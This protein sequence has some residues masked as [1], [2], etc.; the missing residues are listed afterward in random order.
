[1]I[2]R[3]GLEAVERDTVYN[4]VSLGQPRRKSTEEKGIDATNT[5]GDS[6]NSADSA[7]SN[8]SAAPSSR[9]R[10]KMIVFLLILL[11]LCLVVLATGFYVP[12]ARPIAIVAGAV[13]V[14][15]PSV[16]AWWFIIYFR[17]VDFDGLIGSHRWT[18]Y[19]RNLETIWF[20]G[21]P[22]IP[23]IFLLFF[24]VGRYM[25]QRRRRT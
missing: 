9:L 21:P 20:F 16:F 11:V 7:N 5:V 23:S 3:A 18:E 15:F 19:G 24:C 14:Y 1:M 12:T 2:Q 10:D 17:Y 4:R 22:F 13:L 8:K 25:Y 6:S